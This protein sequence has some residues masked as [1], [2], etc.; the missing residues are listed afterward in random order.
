MIG[1]DYARRRDYSAVMA[2]AV[3]G[4]PDFT[5]V[6]PDA[7]RRLG[8]VVTSNWDG[9]PRPHNKAAMKAAK[10]H[11]AAMRRAGKR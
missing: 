11:K 2:A 6:A 4:L 1:T 3:L 10:Q 7:P 5:H 8:C 9:T